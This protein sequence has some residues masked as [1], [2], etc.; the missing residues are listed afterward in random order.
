MPYPPQCLPS[1]WQDLEMAILGLILVGL[2]C[3]LPGNKTQPRGT[4]VGVS[5]G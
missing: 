2:S 3:L 5:M 1:P 4:A